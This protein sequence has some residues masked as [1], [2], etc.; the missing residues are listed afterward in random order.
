[1]LIPVPEGRTVT[2]K[3]YKNV[4]LRKLKKYYKAC[5]PKPG[6]EHLRLLYDN[7]PAHKTHLVTEFLKS[8]MVTVLHPP[9]SPDLPPPT[10]LL[11][12]LPCDYFLFPKLRYHLSGK[13]YNSRNALRSAVY[14][15]LVGV[16]IEE[17]ETASKNGLTG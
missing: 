9:F 10:P 3:F 14:Q 2:A 6:L 15:Y 7:T 17:Y 13:R 1:M 11:P 4:V 8:E 16:L 5:R 12:A